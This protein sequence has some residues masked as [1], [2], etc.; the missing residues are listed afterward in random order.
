MK[1]RVAMVRQCNR[2]LHTDLGRASAARR[3]ADAARLAPMGRAL[4]RE[5]EII[6]PRLIIGLGRDAEGELRSA[7]PEARVLE[8]PFI[9]PHA[10]GPGA[11][12]SPDLLFAKHPSWIKRQHKASLEEEYVTSLARAL[13]WGFRDRPHSGRWAEGGWRKTG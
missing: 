8:W 12:P 4:H 3:D 5:L 11:A 6:Q 2:F 9:V 7:Y 10:T 1:S 13:E